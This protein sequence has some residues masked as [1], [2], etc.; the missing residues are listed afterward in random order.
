MMRNSNNQGIYNCGILTTTFGTSS[1]S[2]T[3]SQGLAGFPASASSSP[4][5]SSNRARAAVA[6]SSW[7]S[8]HQRNLHLT[9]S[10]KSSFPSLRSD[11]KFQNYTQAT[12]RSQG[13]L[14]DDYGGGV[15]VS[16]GRRDDAYRLSQHQHQTT[17]ISAAMPQVPTPHTTPSSRYHHQQ[18]H[19]Q[20]QRTSWDTGRFPRLHPSVDNFMNGL[21]E[22]PKY[23]DEET[24][25]WET[26]E[27]Q[28]AALQDG[29]PKPNDD[30]HANLRKNKSKLSIEELLT[31]FDR[32]KGPDSDD[33]EDIQV[34]LECES[35]VE[36]ATKLQKTIA[37]A[38]DRKDY[39]S[40]PMVQRQVLRWF[41]MLEAEYARQQREFLE[42]TGG[43]G[44]IFNSMAKSETCYGPY[45]CTLSPAKLAV[46]VASET[47]AVCLRT[48]KRDG[49]TFA[50]LTKRIGQA[51]EEEVLIEKLM[52][53][54]AQEKKRRLEKKS[55]EGDDSDD[56][57]SESNHDDNE[58]SSKLLRQA[59]DRFGLSDGKIKKK[60]DNA[61]EASVGNALKEYAASHLQKFL[62]DLIRFD[63][64]ANHRKENN[65]IKAL[66][67]TRKI[68]EDTER[69]SDTRKV[70]VGTAL[71]HVLMENGTITIDGEKQP[72]LNYELKWIGNSKR[73]GFV[74][75]NEQ[76]VKLVKDE[77][78]DWVAR[79]SLRQKPMVVPPVRW[80][81]PSKGGYMLLDTELIRCHGCKMQRELL[82]NSDLSMV[83]D[84]LNV[85]GAVPWRINEKIWDVAKEC[86]EKN[87]A[88]GDIP[89]QTDFEVPVKPIR[90]TN[91]DGKFVPAGAPEHDAVIEKLK[92]YTEKLA[93]Y[94]RIVQKNRDLY[95]L[96]C[97]AALKLD[98]AEKFK[99]F[100]K[101]YF[102]YN[103]D[104][105]GRAYPVPPHLSTIGSDLCR[106]MLTFSTAKPL[107]KRGLYWLKV[108]L[109]NLAGM[110]KVTFDERAAYTDE[111]LAKVR[112]SATDPFGGER[113]WMGLDDPFQ[114]LATCVEII[115]AIDSGDAKS[116]MC[117][118][119]VHMDGSCNGLQ[120]YAALGRDLVG[121]KAVN[122]CATDKPQDVY[123][124]VMHEVIRR[125]SEEAKRPL[126]FDVSDPS[127]LSTKELKEW[128]AKQAAILV[129]GLIDRAVVKRT[130][131]TSVYGVTY[132]GARTQIQEKIEEKLEAAGH[133]IDLM[134]TEIFEACGYLAKITMA[135]MGDLF[136]GAR[137]IMNWLTACARLISK[138]GY[139]VAWI[140]P[141]GLP[142]FQPYRRVKEST[143]TTLR[144]T[145]RLNETSDD[146][147]IHRQ[148]QATAF[149]PNFVHS[150]DSSHMLLTALEMDRRGL[151]FAAVH[152]SFWTHPC[153]VDE[154]NKVLRDVF[155][156]MYEKPVLS[157]V[158]ESWE[159]RYP[160]L[161]FPD[162]PPT[163]E[164]DLTQV[165]DAPYFFQ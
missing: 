54:K 33:L 41:P 112:E 74:H 134:Q 120:H 83:L 98:Q 156:D 82:D 79:Y 125:V 88:L 126:G 159:M 9:V 131:M 137:G 86:H 78:L 4:S 150:L 3:S 164:L 158:K 87:I 18:E 81:S 71:L 40:T 111:N 149:P 49:V 138:K 136:T 42:K 116:Y 147:P 20:H 165:K 35:H 84:G 10:N 121:G 151:T 22:E 51:I 19:N 90:P 160:D 101:I 52:Y 123:V 144:Q 31:T 17:A 80:T 145:V 91:L 64:G 113:W 46:I 24:E 95:G 47:L 163:G 70:Q 55:V 53:K 128:K 30:D 117:L 132:I 16:E 130:V 25:E 103:I 68:L 1:N 59:D 157:V 153:D 37:S 50:V 100:D 97:S 48:S 122:L 152:D 58:Y 85:L 148:R 38:R 2:L 11:L 102:P 146:N 107:G 99:H 104:F 76:F 45:I 23:G 140:S 57:N 105:R 61:D 5:T 108:H 60:K 14:Y 154:M 133:D 12:A 106:G 118:L 94:R 62:K 124:E 161:Q 36:T 44:K 127:K 63:P 142:A 115:N 110:D 114:G 13:N 92:E 109:A 96:R 27:D 65:L 21:S 7:Q 6:R 32:E 39:G 139:P 15:R 69:W 8:N 66:R 89:T 29:Q 28:D 26:M 73:Q 143:V 129:E 135:V 162:I 93:R 34:W 77:D 67:K 43:G 56:S 119:P 155:V 72:A 141:I 75:L